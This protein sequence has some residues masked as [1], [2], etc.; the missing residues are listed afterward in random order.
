MR[1]RSIKPEFWRSQDIDPNNVQVFKDF[2]ESGVGH[3][4]LYLLS[5]SAGRLLYVGITWSP[6]VRWRAHRG[7]HPWW[8]T[9]AHASVW[10]CRDEDARHW[11]TRCIRE[12]EPLHN[13]HQNRRWHQRGKDQDDQAGVLD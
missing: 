2:G 12:L 5:D 4:F 1:I 7:K 10:R 9:V 11:E 13:K 6:F 3:E 8:S